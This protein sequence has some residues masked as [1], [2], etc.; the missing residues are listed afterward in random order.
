M[1]A[2]GGVARAPLSVVFGYQKRARVGV[3]TADGLI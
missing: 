1:K 3:R 2:V